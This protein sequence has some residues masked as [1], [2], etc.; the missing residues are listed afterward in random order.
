MCGK[1][2]NWLDEKYLGRHHQI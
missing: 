1:A 2:E